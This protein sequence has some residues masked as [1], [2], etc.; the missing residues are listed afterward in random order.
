LAESPISVGAALLLIGVVL[1]LLSPQVSPLIDA[2]LGLWG[3]FLALVGIAII[4]VVLS[5]HSTR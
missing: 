2:N 1:N 5:T 3:V 4:A